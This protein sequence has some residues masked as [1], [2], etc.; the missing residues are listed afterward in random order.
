MRVIRRE[1]AGGRR[2]TPG[3][4]MFPGLLTGARE[5]VFL[6]A[7]LHVSL[8]FEQQRFY[9]PHH[10]PEMPRTLQSLDRRVGH[11]E[12]YNRMLY[13]QVMLRLRYK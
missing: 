6:T 12:D 11:G 5:N 1:S 4:L 13:D 7:K 9:N 8:R 2:R 3:D 10:H